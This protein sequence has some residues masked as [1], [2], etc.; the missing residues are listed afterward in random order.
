MTHVRRGW[1]TL[2]SRAGLPSANNRPVFPAHKENKH[3]AGRTKKLA[4]AQETKEAP[5]YEEVY[6]GKEIKGGGSVKISISV[7]VPDH[8]HRR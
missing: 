2:I 5:C 6:S 8:V 4:P 7:G 1:L 3:E